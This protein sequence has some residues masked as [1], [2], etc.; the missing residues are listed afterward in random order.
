MATISINEVKNYTEYLVRKNNS[1]A[2]TPSQFNLVIN[3]AQLSVFMDR[4]GN[5]AE[6]QAGSP[7]PKKGYAITQKI[8]DDMRRF[9]EETN[10]ILNGNGQ[11]NY[12]LDYVH[13]IN[14]KY[15]TQNS[16]NT[17]H[18]PIEIVDQAKEGYRLSS[19]IVPPTK[20]YPIAIM[21]NTFFQFYPNLNNVELN[22][23]RYPKQAV[24]AF[25]MVNSRPVYDAVNS[26]DLEWED[27][28]INDIIIQAMKSIGI[29]IK[30]AE[31]L[32]FAGQ[33]QQKGA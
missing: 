14:L 18:V 19:C 28:V 25:T 26:V 9:T 8:A 7:I 2:L 32:S 4:Y 29:S 11:A 24:W 23:L 10:L 16:G 31:I 17:I 20:K 33:E 6:Y 30:D 22:Y 21:K 3:R 13:A 1:N 27:I 15:V 12:P 5:P